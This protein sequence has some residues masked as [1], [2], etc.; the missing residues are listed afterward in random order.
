MYKSATKNLVTTIY[1]YSLDL[2]VTERFLNIHQL[3]QEFDHYWKKELIN[4]FFQYSPFYQKLLYM[5]EC[6]KLQIAHRKVLYLS[7]VTLVLLVQPFFSL[8]QTNRY[9]EKILFSNG[10]FDLVLSK[11]SKQL[12]MTCFSANSWETLQFH[13]P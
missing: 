10:I 11:W 12:R 9:T 8:N 6:D 13:I 5:S 3:V 1:K 2:W 7:L 4:R